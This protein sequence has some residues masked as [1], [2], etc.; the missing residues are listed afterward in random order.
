MSSAV[1]RKLPCPFCKI[2]RSLGHLFEDYSVD[3]PNECKLK[4]V[5]EC[6][7]RFFV[8]AS[9]C[10]SEVKFL[11]HLFDFFKKLQMKSEVRRKQLLLSGLVDAKISQLVD[12]FSEMMNV[13]Q[14][15]GESIQ[16]RLLLD[17]ILQLCRLALVEQCH[18][19]FPV[20]QQELQNNLTLLG[21]VI[22]DEIVLH[23]LKKRSCLDELGYVVDV[24]YNP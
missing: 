17:Q 13:R 15:L 3:D 22:S 4:V 20:N 24:V 2:Y 12:S 7:E 14:K 18:S 1:Q 21:R 5:L 10:E 11:G 6:V 23:M 8:V 16:V 19:F 9:G